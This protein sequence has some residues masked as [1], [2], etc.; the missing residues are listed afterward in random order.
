MAQINITEL[1]ASFIHIDAEPSILQELREYFTFRVPGAEF[2][3]SVRNHFWDGK[4][5]LLDT[6]KKTL[7]SG[8][9]DE[10][11]QVA[12]EMGYT[13]SFTPK[14]ERRV[15]T[16]QD[17]R[18]R[19][20]EIK[21]TLEIRPYQMTAILN[22]LNSGRQLMLSPTASGKSMIIYMLCRMIEK[23]TLIIVPTTALVEQMTSDFS[24]YG[25]DSENNVH[26]IYYGKDRNTEKQVTVTTW[27]TLAKQPSEYFLQFDVV[28]GDECHLFAAKSLIKIMEALTNTWY[29]IGATGSLD[30][31]K[32]HEMVIQ[33][34]FGP[35]SR[36][37]TTRELMDKG[38]LA[39]L[40]IKCL[41]LTHSQEDAKKVR[42]MTY[43]E[44]IEFLFTMPKRNDF[45][46]DLVS[47]MK[48]NVLVLCQYVDK[49]AIPLHDLMKEKI[50]KNRNI[51]LIVGKV[52]PE[53]RE[54]IRKILETETDAILVASIKSF[55]TGSNVKNLRHVVFT[56]P[57]KSMVTT[58]QSI[59]R[60]IRKSPTKTRATLHDI[61]DNLT[62]KGKKNFSQEH[63]LKRLQIYSVEK[64][65][66]K[67]FNIG[68]NSD[69]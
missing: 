18:D 38:Y 47:K 62:Y 57:T 43:Q 40:D 21:L 55:A 17:V 61:A 2:H 35:I 50:P 1:N 24:D 6:R 29:R 42:P 15:F 33:G 63:F 68:L 34:L 30:G 59:G 45:I 22:A 23:K 16:E 8:L 41:V 58:L 56:A 48:G 49:H 26:K 60:A 52:D 54:K 10:L 4:I 3:P 44:E 36:V 31:T 25:F 28:I 20:K 32:T 65:P 14:F 7:Y 9:K 46:V 69:E 19:A 67:I 27:Q 5:R 64:F 13:A 66:Y 12:K 37:A 39:E 11:L 53:E 51:Y